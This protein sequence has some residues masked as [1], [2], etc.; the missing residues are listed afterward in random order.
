[1]NE[2]EKALE[3]INIRIDLQ[4]AE[5]DGV[6]H[7]Q[8]CDRKLASA[9]QEAIDNR[10]ERLEGLNKS[11]WEALLS[12]IGFVKANNEAQDESFEHQIKK[13]EERIEKLGG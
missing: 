8:E 12:E 4:E 6:K 1:M 10:I 2:N 5:L 9:R 11:Q 7:I 13:L 3:A